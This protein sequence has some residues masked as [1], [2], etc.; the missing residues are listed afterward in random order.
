MDLSL[1][2][3]NQTMYKQIYQNKNDSQNNIKMDNRAKSA[4]YVQ[5]LKSIPTKNLGGQSGFSTTTVRFNNMNKTNKPNKNKNRTTDNF[6]N[7]NNVALSTSRQMSD[8]DLFKLK[9]H[10]EAMGITFKAENTIPSEHKFWNEINTD[11]HFYCQ[12]GADIRHTVRN[13]YDLSNKIRMISNTNN[14]ENYEFERIHNANTDRVN[15]A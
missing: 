2:A 13:Q 7:F 6:N 10:Y 11:K 15:A 9:L 1:D 5:S 12:F 14:S 4:N 3:I 8:N